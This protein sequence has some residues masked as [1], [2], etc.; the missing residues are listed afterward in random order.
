[1]SCRY[2]AKRAS[3]FVP[4]NS[5]HRS[6]RTFFRVV[7]KRD[8][9]YRVILHVVQTPRDFEPLQNHFMRGPKMSLFL[10]RNGDFLLLA[11]EPSAPIMAFMRYE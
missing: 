6:P 10:K 5:P 9:L 3:V 11:T 1:M 7:S 2:L 8:T 4:L